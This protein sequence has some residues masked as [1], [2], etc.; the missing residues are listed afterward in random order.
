VALNSVLALAA[1]LD[2]EWLRI[3]P[4]VKG[5]S[6]IARRWANWV[7]LPYGLPPVVRLGPRPDGGLYQR[8]AVVARQHVHGPMHRYFHYLLRGELGRGA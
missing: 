3:Q 2:N 4:H 6:R 7:L 1:A 8:A 5:T